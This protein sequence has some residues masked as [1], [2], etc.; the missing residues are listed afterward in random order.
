M[1]IKPIIF[2]GPSEYRIS[3]TITPL[4]RAQ[5]SRMDEKGGETHDGQP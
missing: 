3:Q 1:T 4:P 2:S 5:I